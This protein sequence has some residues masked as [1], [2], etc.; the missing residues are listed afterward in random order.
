MSLLEKNLRVYANS[1][2]LAAAE[3]LA[4]L[5]KNHQEYK[6]KMEKSADLETILQAS[7]DY[8][9]TYEKLKKSWVVKKGV[10]V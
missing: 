2:D 10:G 4:A 1:G 5:K 8:I 7:A 3:L 6:E 9:N